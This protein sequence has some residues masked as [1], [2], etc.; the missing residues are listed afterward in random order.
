MLW[1]RPGEYGYLRFPTVT[2]GRLREK[3]KFL[4]MLKIAPRKI[5]DGGSVTVDPGTSRSWLD[6]LSRMQKKKWISDDTYAVIREKREAKR[7]DK[8]RYQELKTEVQNKL[9]VNNSSSWRHVRGIRIS[10]RERKFQTG[11]SDSQIKDSKVPTT[12]LQCIQSATGENLTEA[13]QIA[14]RW[15]GY[16]KDLYTKMRKGMELHHIHPALIPKIGEN[17][18]TVALRFPMQARWSY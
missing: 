4:N 18:R 7:K 11:L 13:A 9:T 15:K 1:L 10:K 8:N 5:Q 6:P 17:C 2:C 12:R 16:C 3:M 14:D